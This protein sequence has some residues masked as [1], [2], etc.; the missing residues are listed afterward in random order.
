M[1]ARSALIHE[2]ILKLPTHESTKLAVKH[3]RDMLRLCRG[4]NLGIRDLVPGCYIRLGKDQEA[5]DFLKWWETQTAD[6]EWGDTDLPYLNLKDEDIMEEPIF[7][8]RTYDVA[9]K[10]SLLLLK[11]SILIPQTR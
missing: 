1:R 2:L 8:E 6:Y 10:I 11:V 5:Y 7:M 3:A 4:D 9:M